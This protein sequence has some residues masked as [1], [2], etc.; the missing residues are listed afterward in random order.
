MNNAKLL[1]ELFGELF[2]VNPRG[3]IIESGWRKLE[4]I[5]MATPRPRA[6][7]VTI[8]G[9]RPTARMYNPAKYTTWKESLAY[10][11]KTSTIIPFRY[12][13]IDLIIC[14]AIPKSRK[15]SEKKDMVWNYH[16][17]KP[18]F[19]N[20]TK[21]VLDAIQQ[22]GKVSDDSVFGAGHIEKVWIPESYK[23]FILFN[24][25]CFSRP[26]FDTIELIQKSEL[27]L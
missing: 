22:S 8:P 21:G 1:D 5:P 4:I 11:I 17:Q 13:H 26:H 27:I 19:D 7:A 3:L 10:R 18:D 24:L 2:T 25:Q 12:N 23:G 6:V 15:K 9:Q 16:D 14:S 20:F